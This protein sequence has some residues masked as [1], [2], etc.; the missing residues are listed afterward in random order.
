MSRPSIGTAIYS[1]KLWERLE[2]KPLQPHAGATRYAQTPVCGTYNSAKTRGNVGR[3][4]EFQP[5]RSNPQRRSL[6]PRFDRPTARTLYGG[7]S[8]CLRPGIAIFEPDY[9]GAPFTPRQR[10]DCREKCHPHFFHRTDYRAGRHRVAQAWLC[11][12]A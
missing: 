8:N 7:G 12:T 3:L 10:Q 1:A 6:E 4:I 9:L 2:Y 11:K 5:C